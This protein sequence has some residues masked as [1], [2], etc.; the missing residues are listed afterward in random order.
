MKLS[1]KGDIIRNDDKWI[2]DFFEIEGCC[3]KDVEAAIEKCADG[4]PLD[5]EISSGGGDVIAGSEIY[6]ALSGYKKG[7][8]TIRVTGLAA[9]AASVIAMAGHCEMAR[10]ALM[11]IHNTATV[12]RGDYRDME[13]AA[14]VLRAANEA[15]RSAYKA[16]TGRSEEE[17]AEM[18]DRETWIPAEKAVKL[19]FADGIM[20]DE[21][22]PVLPIAAAI[23]TSLSAEALEKLRARIKTI[24]DAE[25][26]T[27]DNGHA[28][29]AR[30]EADYNFMLLKGA[31]R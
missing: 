31:Q 9:S 15:I 21:E 14:E 6:T 20:N 19:G 8:L 13:H 27:A 16:K 5:V 10:T 30:A 4:E 3:P 11:M 18:M 28:A 17:L 2:Y 25:K 1:I 26:G 23:G 29:L 7:E 12:A 24:Q 22:A